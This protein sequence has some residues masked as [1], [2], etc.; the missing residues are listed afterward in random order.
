MPFNH[1]KLTSFG[2][3]QNTS[4]LAAYQ[5]HRIH[6]RHPRRYH[7]PITTALRD[8]WLVL[9]RFM[10]DVSA[11]CSGEKRVA[12]GRL[13]RPVQMLD[14]TESCKTARCAD[15]IKIHHSALEYK[16]CSIKELLLKSMKFQRIPRLTPLKA[17]RLRPAQKINKQSSGCCGLSRPNANR[18]PSQMKIR[19]SS[20]LEH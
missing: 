15:M 1:W 13:P 8:F 4:F 6:R 18:S 2:R 20:D 7:I 5:R 12:S 10:S 14:P 9:V 16:F 17:A 19:I 3:L 11:V